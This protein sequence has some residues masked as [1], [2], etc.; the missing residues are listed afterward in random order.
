MSA[1]ESSRAGES[2]SAQHSMKDG[3]L[4]ILDEHGNPV[5]EPDPL[6]WADWIEENHEKRSIQ[7]DEVDG[8]T[9]STV[10]LGSDMSF[11]SNKPELFETIVFGDDDNMMRR[12]AT[13]QEALQGHLE[14]L[15]QVK[16]KVKR[17]A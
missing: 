14:V 12:Y 5:P 15:Y 2:K 7:L 8:Y 4:Y 1:S 16:R 17:A 6:K 11:M 9:V 3:I 10:F 13:K